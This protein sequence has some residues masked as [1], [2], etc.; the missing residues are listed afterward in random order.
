MPSE[1]EIDNAYWQCKM[2]RREIKKNKFMDL[3]ILLN[4]G[5]L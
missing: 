3:I 2:V 4:F 5:E 1:N